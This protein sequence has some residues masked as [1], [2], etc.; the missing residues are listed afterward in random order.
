MIEDKRKD[1]LTKSKTEEKTQLP[2]ITSESNNFLKSKRKR[3]TVV[4]V[5]P[6]SLIEKITN[7]LKHISE[8]LSNS[9]YEVS[10]KETLN[11]VFTYL[12][13][14]KME[15]S[16]EILKVHIIYYYF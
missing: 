1:T 16:I 12:N 3:D 9:E 2:V 4:L 13:K 8:N 15:N 14:Y 11:R 7:Y 10:E 6:G 5:E